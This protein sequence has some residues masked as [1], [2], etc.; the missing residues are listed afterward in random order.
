MG[1]AFIE[2]IE[3]CRDPQLLVWREREVHRSLKERFL[4]L[5]WRP[6]RKMKKES[7]QI[8]DPDI[9]VV[10]PPPQ[11]SSLFPMMRLKQPAFIVGHPVTLDK[12]RKEYF[13]NEF[14]VVRQVRDPS[15]SEEVQ[16]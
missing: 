8:P 12:L 14:G 7:Y 9:Y 15:G 6:W 11:S 3:C 5:P 10:D 16:R 1:L 13:D 2:G 4:T